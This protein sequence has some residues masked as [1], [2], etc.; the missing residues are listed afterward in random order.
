VFEVGAGGL[1]SVEDESG[2][3]LGDAGVDER[4][5]GFHESDLDGVGVLED[6]HVEGVVAGDE[7]LGALGG[8]SAALAGLVVEVAEAT[9]LECGRAAGFSVGLEVLAKWY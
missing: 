6:G 7:R 1:K 5:Y 8:G 3:A 4:V 9:M 2:L